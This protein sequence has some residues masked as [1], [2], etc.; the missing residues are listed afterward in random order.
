[1]TKNNWPVAECDEFL[2]NYRQSRLVFQPL[3]CRKPAVKQGSSFKDTFIHKAEPFAAKHWRGELARSIHAWRARYLSTTID[4]SDSD[5]FLGMDPL[6]RWQTRCPFYVNAATANGSRAE[7]GNGLGCYGRCFRRSN[8]QTS[9]GNDRLPSSNHS[10]L[11]K[12]RAFEKGVDAERRY[13]W[14][15]MPL[16]YNPGR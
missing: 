14:H 16:S 15:G 7:E 2:N 10:G 9:S 11:K 1:M 5:Y 13:W 6:F 12:H 3:Q 8:C 4:D